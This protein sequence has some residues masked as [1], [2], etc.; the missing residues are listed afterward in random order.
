MGCGQIGELNEKVNKNE[1]EIVTLKIFKKETEEN[2]K[3]KADFQEIENLKESELKKNNEELQ[4]LKESNEKIT[5][6]LEQ[7][8]T[9]IKIKNEEL[10]QISKDFNDFK[11]QYEPTIND[12]KQKMV[13]IEELNKQVNEYKDIQQKNINEIENLKKYIETMEKQERELKKSNLTMQS[14]NKSPSNLIQSELLIKPFNFSNEPRKIILE[15]TPDYMNTILQCLF[16]TKKLAKF[17]LENENII[18]MNGLLSFEFNNL[19][20]ILWKQRITNINPNNFIKNFSEIKNSTFPGLEVLTPKLFLEKLLDTIHS[21]LKIS[22]SFNNGTNISGGQNN[23]N[24]FNQTNDS[25]ISN[26][27]DIIFQLKNICQ[28]GH[29]S[30]KFEIYR[31]LEFKICQL[32]TLA[33][34]GCI[35]INKCFEQIVNQQI[36][37]NKICQFCNVYKTLYKSPP[38]LIIYI[39]WENVNSECKVIFPE[40]LNLFINTNYELYATV[41]LFGKSYN[42]YVKNFIDFKW[43]YYLYGNFYEQQVFNIDLICQFKMPHLLFYKSIGNDY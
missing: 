6:E 31:I 14:I 32:S 19:L 15:E 37:E 27:F 21:E 35:D 36:N 9:E 18:K 41:I 26:L 22:K 25:I 7:K 11:E 10:A 28:N 42:A 2:L 24:F 16:Y 33:N 17:F 29:S 1:E 23:F 13:K 4:K 8:I 39:N 43:Y 30:N 38:Y 5:K 40:K 3:K 12:M 34:N 20:K